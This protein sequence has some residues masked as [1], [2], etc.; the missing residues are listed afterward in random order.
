MIDL[1]RLREEGFAVEG[2]DI[3]KLISLLR[4]VD[5]GSVASFI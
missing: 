3:Q 5:D 2:Y 4:L 1:N